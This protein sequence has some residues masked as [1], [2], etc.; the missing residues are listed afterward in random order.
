MLTGS[1][2]VKYLGECEYLQ[3]ISSRG[4]DF[5]SHQWNA[6]VE[7]ILKFFVFLHVLLFTLR[8]GILKFCN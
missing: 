6:S 4:L 7:C 2:P 5:L 3:N 1:S 8:S